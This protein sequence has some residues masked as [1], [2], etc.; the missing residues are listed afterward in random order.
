M[1]RFATI[2]KRGGLTSTLGD[3]L[4]FSRHGAGVIKGELENMRTD[5]NEDTIKQ[6]QKAVD[7]TISEGLK[8]GEDFY[9]LYLG[10]MN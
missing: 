4:A 8:P 9:I 1:I 6:L 2:A 7:D 10:K 3:R 5:E